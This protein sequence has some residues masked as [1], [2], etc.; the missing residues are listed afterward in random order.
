MDWFPKFNW[1]LHNFET[2]TKPTN[3]SEKFKVWISFQTQL[4]DKEHRDQNETETGST[5][6]EIQRQTNTASYSELR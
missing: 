6:N 1:T 3:Q 4:N 5:T 2:T